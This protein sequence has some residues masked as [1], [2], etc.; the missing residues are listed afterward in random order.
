MPDIGVAGNH[1]QRQL[2]AATTDQD[3]RR[4]LDRLWVE[5]TVGHPYVGPFV[6]DLLVRVAAPKELRDVERLA[7]HPDPR[8]RLAEGEVE[9]LNLPFGPARADAE[10]EAPPQR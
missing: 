8:L 5:E 10:I 7:E 1:A 3:R 9:R 2:L 6:G 4:H